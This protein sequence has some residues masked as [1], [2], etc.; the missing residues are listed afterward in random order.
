MIGRRLNDKVLVNW[1]FIYIWLPINQIILI[2]QAFIIDR[3]CC[4]FIQIHYFEKN[5][6]DD[7]YV[8]ITTFYELNLKKFEEI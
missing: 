5:D 6:Y 1:F 4:I 2:T 3:I 7:K 8:Y